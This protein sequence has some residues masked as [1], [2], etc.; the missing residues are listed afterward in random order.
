VT[1]GVVWRADQVLIAQR[2][3]DGLL[4]GMWEFPGGKRESDETLVDC[5]KRELYEELGIEVDVGQQLTVVRHAYTHFR[6]TVY[7]FEC[8]YRSTGEPTAREVHD[9][10]WVTPDELDDYALPVVD[11]KITAIVRDGWRQGS[12]LGDAT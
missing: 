12:F 5:L 2:P 1:A 9:W 3:L 6:I 7:A 11:R 4:G 10:R 8:R